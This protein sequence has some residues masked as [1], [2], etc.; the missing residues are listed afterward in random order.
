MKSNHLPILVVV[1]ALHLMGPSTDAQTCLA[2]TMHVEITNITVEDDGSGALSTVLHISDP[3][4][5]ERVSGYNIYRSPTPSA[6]PNLWWLLAHD[7]QDQNAA[8]TT[9][10][11]GDAS[12]DLSPSGVFYYLAAAINGPC[13]SEGP[14]RMPTV[15]DT[16]ADMVADVDDPCPATPAGM[17][18]LT[19]GCSA[20]DLLLQPERLVSP[21]DEGLGAFLADISDV[22]D[23]PIQ[24]LPSVDEAR[25]GL[26]AVADDLRA[27]MPCSAAP[28][29][30]VV[31]G[32]LDDIVV[33]VEEHM[34]MILVAG[35]ASAGAEG[36]GMGGASGT[37]GSF[38]DPP[39]DWLLWEGL[40]FKFMSTHDA[41]TQSADITN[42]I[43]AA[44]GVAV[45]LQGTVRR[46]SD[47]ERMIELDS[48]EQIV[49]SWA[50]AVQGGDRLAPDRSF[51]IQGYAYE[52]GAVT[53]GTAAVTQ[54][55]PFPYIDTSQYDGCLQLRV[56]PVQPLPGAPYPQTSWEKHPTVS[57][58]QGGVLAFER[59]TKLMTEDTGCPGVVPGLGPSGEDV[60]IDYYIELGMNY[61]PRQGNWINGVTLA[62]K[63]SGTSF[64]ILLSDMDPGTDAQMWATEVK[65][66]CVDGGTNLP[67]ISTQNGNVVGFR[68][69]WHCSSE[70]TV[71]TTF[72]DLRV[73]DPQAYCDL[74]YSTSLFDIEDHDFTTWQTTSV[75]GVNLAPGLVPGPVTFQAQGSK[76]V[77]NN[78]VSSWWG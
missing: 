24:I 8:T 15:E 14:R 16:D 32:Y 1:M 40:L 11:W 63:A 26:Q 18:L 49:S 44:Q 23:I 64:P 60:R 4:P 58:D 20:T 10:D 78:P 22:A 2:P 30:Q 61:Q 5:A 38:T 50:L 66:T 45:D 13:D 76:I 25:I 43:C 54:V 70:Q 59:G 27:V 19:P 41:A 57:Y 33:A 21:V 75:T 53:I 71:G 35:G 48:G 29:Y 36:G 55:S 17:T 12:G 56:L 47:S 42:Q 74:S 72:Y 77:G 31:L 37:D 46:I 6:P 3:N 39:T 73:R 28:D 51:D 34:D 67:V 69:L 62:Y 65:R 7:A 9:I 68:R 52:G